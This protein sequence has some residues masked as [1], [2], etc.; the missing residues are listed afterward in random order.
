[1][2]VKRGEERER[3]KCGRMC[4][5]HQREVICPSTPTCKSEIRE[6]ETYKVRIAIKGR[7]TVR[8][9]WAESRESRSV[10]VSGSKSLGCETIEEK[11]EWH[12]SLLNF[13]LSRA[14]TLTVATVTTARV[15]LR[16]RKRRQRAFAILRACFAYI[17]Q[18]IFSLLFSQPSFSFYRPAKNPLLFLLL[19]SFPYVSPVLAHTLFTFIIM[20]RPSPSPLLPLSPG[21]L[22]STRC[23]NSS[24]RHIPRSRSS[25]TSLLNYNCVKSQPESE[26]RAAFSATVH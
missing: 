11:R 12:R 10:C 13:K 20:K 1:M 14:A 2:K 19:L 16:K 9:S 26:V 22:A 24:L 7:A 17:I 21:P 6:R 4:R 5:I 8:G 23:K 15:F 18:R 3:G 25:V